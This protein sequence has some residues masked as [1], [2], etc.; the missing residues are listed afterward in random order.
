MS[1]VRE[2]VAHMLQLCHY[3]LDANALADI[4]VLKEKARIVQQLLT[5]E[6]VHEGCQDKG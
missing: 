6:H 2:A 5:E 1:Q 4:T 3:V